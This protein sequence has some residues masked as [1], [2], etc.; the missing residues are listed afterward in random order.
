M[1]AFGIASMF[2]CAFCMFTLYQGWQT[3]GKII[4]GLALVLLMVSMV[5]S[6]WEIQISVKAL[7]LELSDLE[8]EEIGEKPIT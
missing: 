7:E 3:A 6:L 2:C 1:Q 8:Q 4:F 5:L